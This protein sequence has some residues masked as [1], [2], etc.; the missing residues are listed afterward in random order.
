MN[1]Q[2]NYMIDDVDFGTQGFFAIYRN[3]LDWCIVAEMYN[4]RPMISLTKTL[5]T[6]EGHN[7]NKN[8]Y[9]Y[10]F[11]NPYK[12]E[13]KDARKNS[14]Y[15]VADSRHVY[16]LNKLLQENP[17]EVMSYQQHF[18]DKY[19]ELMVNALKK[20]MNPLP[21][22]KDELIKSINEKIG[23]HKTVGVHYRNWV[24]PL[25][26]HPVPVKEEQIVKKVDDCLKNGF[27]KVFLATDDEKMI[28]K[29]RARY[30]SALCYYD[31]V[32]RSQNDSEIQFTQR[33]RKDD[34]YYLGKEVYRD[35]YTLAHCDGLIAGH[36]QVSF[37]AR[38]QRLA[39]IGE[40]EYLDIINNGLYTGSSVAGAKYRKWVNKKARS[41]INEKK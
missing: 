21:E 16:F 6:R 37:F 4:F 38:L 11:V 17:D 8:F 32:A 28:E 40:Y 26:G 3:V 36:S 30:G 14:N 10:Y 7:G 41:I 1:K 13:L 24:A 31:D 29:L 5:Y 18:S 39:D 2:V 25:Y 12:E 22:L 19:I 33:N 15:V 34:G 20:Y 9:E 23:N 27:E 35:M